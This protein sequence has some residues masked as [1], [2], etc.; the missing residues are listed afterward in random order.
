MTAQVAAKRKLTTWGLIWRGGLVLVLIAIVSITFLVGLGLYLEHK[1]RVF[2]AQSRRERNVQTYDAFWV[3]ISDHYYNPKFG[4][5]GWA[6]LRAEGRAKAANAANGIRL[7]TD[8]L[9]PMAQMLPSSHVA[10]ILAD[11][12]MDKPKTEPAKGPV[13]MGGMDYGFDFDCLRRLGTSFCTVGDVKRGSTADTAGIEPGWVITNSNTTVTVAK[14]MVTRA[15]FEVDVYPYIA[16]HGHF[17]VVNGRADMTV[18]TGGADFR[19]AV[20]HI[21]YDLPLNATTPPPFAARRLP[22]GAFY[23]RFDNF[24]LAPFDTKATDEAIAALDHADARG[25]IIDLRHNTGGEVMTTMRFISHFLPPLT[26]VG[27]FKG[28]KFTD[29]KR[30]DFWSKRYHG[31]V[32]V[33]TGPGAYSGAELTAAALKYHHRATLIGRT[34]NGSLLESKY[35]NL[36][37]GGKVQVPVAD[38]HT[39]DGQRVEDV[40]VKPDIEV[41]PTLVEIRT[42]DDPVLERAEVVLAKDARH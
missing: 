27:F 17:S 39:P 26:E 18:D 14:G 41:I 1:G 22:S 24:G 37:D 40:G 9:M 5:L 13:M 4:G 28:R 19:T 34:T 42:G 15:H 12:A 20:R 6:A 23:V 7:Y 38:F 31:P 3:A 36:P 2:W 30:T 10:A 21:E 16:D 8:V 35:F 29:V 33:L 11:S 32:A 25:V